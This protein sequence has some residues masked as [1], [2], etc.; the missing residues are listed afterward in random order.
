MLDQLNEENQE[1][2]AEI[3]H[4]KKNSINLNQQ[5]QQVQQVQRQG[6]SEEDYAEFKRAMEEKE[7]EISQINAQLQE[8]EEKFNYMNQNFENKIAYSESIEQQL[9]AK[10]AE[11]S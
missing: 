7:Y 3:E 10:N 1:M 11:V 9:E 4:Y 5:V 2:N 8:Y 6:P